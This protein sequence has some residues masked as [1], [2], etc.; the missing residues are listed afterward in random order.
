[1]VDTNILVSGLLFGGKPE[2]ILNEIAKG[3]VCGHCSEYLLGE[4]ARVASHKFKVGKE[5]VEGIDK[6][7]REILVIHDPK[8]IPNLVRDAADN[9]VLAIADEAKMDYIIS[10][11]KDLLV[12]K[13]YKNV[14]IVTADEFLSS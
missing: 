1:M 4:L 6:L 5:K 13:G 10:G 11:D 2:K 3:N 7:M 8:S 12:L 14:P 9:N